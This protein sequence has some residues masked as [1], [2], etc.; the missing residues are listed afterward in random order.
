MA[1]IGSRP[2]K[3]QNLFCA[4]APLSDANFS[5]SFDTTFPLHDNQRCTLTDVPKW[6]KFNV[7]ETLRGK[8]LALRQWTGPSAHTTGERGRRTSPY[9]PGAAGRKLQ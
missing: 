1:D 3:T 5:Q 4:N 8:R 7:F 6:L 2:T 9:T